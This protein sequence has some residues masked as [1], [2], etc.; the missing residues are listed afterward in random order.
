MNN[1]DPGAFSTIV[2]ALYARAEKT[3]GDLAYSVEGGA[4]TYGGLLEEVLGAGDAL[5]ALGLEPDHRCALILPTGLPFVR[6]CFAAQALGAAP[7][8]VNPSLP[9]ETALG[10][11]ERAGADLVIC[12]GEARDELR[13]L[14]KARARPP[15][16]E[17][18]EDLRAGG[19]LAAGSLPRPK[20]EQTAYLQ[21][22]SG[23]SGEPR[24]AVILHRNLIA[25]LRSLAAEG[26]V[27]SDDVF[28]SWLP[29]HHDL[30]LVRCV[31]LP[32]Y[33]GRPAHLIP[34]SIRNLRQ[35]LETISAVRGT[36]TA[37]PDFGYR[38]A[39]RTVSPDGLDLTSLRLATN[40]GEPVRGSTLE[41]F[42]KRFGLRRI[43]RPS[44]G[45][46]EATLT[47]AQF[48]TGEEVRI[49]PAGA[50]SCGRPLPG[51]EV[52]IVDDDGSEVPPGQAGEIVV[53]AE[54]VFAGYHGDAEATREVLRD[55][56]LHTGDVGAL[57][58]DGHL[59]VLGRKRALIKRAGAVIPPREV[60]EAADR[61]PGVRY[62]AAVGV[63][64]ESIGGSEGVVV[65]AE[66]RPEDVPTGDERARLAAAVAAEVR[67]A[68]GSAPS[69]VLLVVPH[70]IPRTPN[71]KIRYQELRR[72]VVEGVLTREGAVLFGGASTH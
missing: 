55:G 3:P 16:V 66:I 46:A 44:Y 64:D 14:A 62:S 26:R 13:G 32:L 56:R 7:V 30:G 57:D 12:A 54:A 49:G 34:P 45:L 21:I 67:R 63:P 71:G 19:R 27:L 68:L 8:A 48:P 40:G 35:W 9:P 36:I 72:L 65:V 20:P 42:E 2:D 58:A 47:V 25:C 10:R 69:D 11:V 41:A 33:T 37:S 31:L 61:V 53:K 52:T 39:T 43:V 29:L 5:T 38:V 59:Y 28:V 24:A 6:T 50:V 18:V 70:A 51:V 60:E 4:V 17:A 23:T 1:V 22:T 15:R